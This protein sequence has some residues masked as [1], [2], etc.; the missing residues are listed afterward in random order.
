MYLQVLWAYMK[1]CPLGTCTPAF[2]FETLSISP[3]LIFGVSVGM[4][5]Y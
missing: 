1:I 4:Y 5:K 2:Y 3:K